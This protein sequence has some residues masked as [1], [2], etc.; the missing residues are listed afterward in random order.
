MK[1]NYKFHITGKDVLKIAFA[2]GIGFR[3]GTT[4]GKIYEHT[5][6]VALKLMG[7]GIRFLINPI[8]TTEE[9]ADDGQNDIS[10]SENHYEEIVDETVAE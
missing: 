2:A 9:T 4:C 7:T 3:L 8:E 1:T 10:D 5:V 6:L